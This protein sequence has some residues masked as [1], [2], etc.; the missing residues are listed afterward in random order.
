MPP[1][2]EFSF[3]NPGARSLGLGGAFAA[4]ADDATAAYANLAGLVQLVEPEVSIEVRRLSFETPY[5]EG[6]RLFGEPFGIGLD[7]T[8]RLREG[9]SS[10][11]VGAVSFLAYVHQWGD[12]SFALF[13]H[14]VADFDFQGELNGLFSGPWPRITAVRREFDVRHV[15]DFDLVSTA[16]SGGWQVNEALSVGFGAAR[17]EG[18]LSSTAESFGQVCGG[19]GFDPC[20]PEVLANFFAE[21][22]LVPERLTLSAAFEIDDTASG[23]VTG[24]LW[25]FSEGWKLGTFFRQGPELDFEVV[26]RA[27]PAHIAAPAGALIDAG[28]DALKF[29]DVFGLGLSY[30]AAGDRLSLSF[31]WDRVEYSDLADSIFVL[32]DADE[33]H[34]GLEY[35]FLGATPMPALRL[36]VWWNPDHRIRYEGT[37]Y[38][39]RGLL[40]GVTRSISRSAWA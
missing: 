8:F 1:T 4:L 18:R 23:L 16:L 10:E 35:A 2:F 36:G 33:L 32:E 28:A 5:V 3:S 39:S 19:T 13:R 7:N 9:R 6:G 26:E 14:Q 31:E 29:P 27:G 40:R 25:G 38:L 12:W 22:P 30:R 24:L 11:D 34:F 15:V 20:P 37:S 21:R 17:F